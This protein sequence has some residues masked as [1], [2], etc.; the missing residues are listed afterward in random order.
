LTGFSYRGQVIPGQ[1]CNLK[2]AKAIGNMSPNFV[3][4]SGGKFQATAK[5][6][7]NRAVSP[8]CLL[9]RHI[10]NPLILNGIYLHGPQIIENITKYLTGL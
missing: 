2:P 6:R 7:C 9:I 8:D 4:N 5:I 10:L 1:G 3:D